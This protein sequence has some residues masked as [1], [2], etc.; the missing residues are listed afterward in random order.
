MCT[1]E[2]KK[3]NLLALDNKIDNWSP[4]RYCLKGI[5]PMQKDIQ[6]SWQDFSR[7]I[8]WICCY[9]KKSSLIHF[10][11]LIIESFSDYSNEIWIR[12]FVKNTSITQNYTNGMHAIY[13]EKEND[14]LL[15][16]FPID[17]NHSSLPELKRV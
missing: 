10:T 2:W 6:I 17:V 16:N 3:S 13:A 1:G 12:I 5:P 7:C 14:Q 15:T 11:F 9:E 4:S 8:F